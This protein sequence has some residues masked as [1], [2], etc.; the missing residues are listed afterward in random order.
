MKRLF[1]LL[2]VGCIIF[3]GCGEKEIIDVKG[4]DTVEAAE[5]VEAT[6]K[7]T[8]QQDVQTEPSQQVVVFV[9]GEVKKPGVYELDED[10]RIIDAISLAGGYTEDAC[11]LYLNLAGA[12]NDEQKIYVPSKMEVEEGL[13]TSEEMSGLENVNNA[14]KAGETRININKATKEELMTLPGIGES[15]AEKIIAYREENGVFASP[16]GIMQISGIKDG[17]YNK[18]KDRICAK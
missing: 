1:V 2:V 11:D 8:T 7:V 9:C 6:Q 3:S 14:G 4:M 5:I 10:S 18:I 12:V 15:K 17:L 16:E 13:L